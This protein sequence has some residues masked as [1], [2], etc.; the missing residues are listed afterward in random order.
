MMKQIYRCVQAEIAS[1]K[2]SSSLRGHASSRG[3]PNSTSIIARNLVTSTSGGSGAYMGLFSSSG[4]S[5]RS[6]SQASAPMQGRM[7]ALSFTPP[8]PPPPH[9]D[10]SHLEKGAPAVDGVLS[11][12]VLASAGTGGPGAGGALSLDGDGEDEESS[13]LP[14]RTMPRKR[15]PDPAASAAS[16]SAPFRI[17]KESERRQQQISSDESKQIWHRRY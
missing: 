16:A 8:C 11:D 3:T 2:L 9:H 14:S 17:L 6:L 15:P 7:A 1:P 5:L 13:V 12:G 10:T 4:Q